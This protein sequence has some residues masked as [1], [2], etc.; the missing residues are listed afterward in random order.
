MSYW[1]HYA[2]QSSFRGGWGSNISH[3]FTAYLYCRLLMPDVVERVS[4]HDGER[5]V[6]PDERWIPKKLFNKAHTRLIPVNRFQCLAQ[7]D[8]FY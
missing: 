5:F 8:V 3:P 1:S 2:I 4:D 7:L 6:N